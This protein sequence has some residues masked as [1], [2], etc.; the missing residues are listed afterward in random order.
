MP[1]APWDPLNHVQAEQG[2]SQGWRHTLGLAACSPDC[3]CSVPATNCL[4]AAAPE[5]HVYRRCLLSPSWSPLGLGSQVCSGCLRGWGIVLIARC[6]PGKQ[7]GPES[8][9]RAATP[10][11]WRLQVP[12]GLGQS[13]RAL[14]SCSLGSFFSWG[15]WDLHV[16]SIDKPS[17]ALTSL[18]LA[19]R[20][21]AAVSW[22]PRGPRLPRA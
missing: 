21:C 7:P 12:D 17:L 2:Q 9:P 18:L 5:A 20:A 6:H 11:P 4:V 10:S 16:R 1:W 19:R 15:C 22:Y 3:P 14:C 8:W 13:P